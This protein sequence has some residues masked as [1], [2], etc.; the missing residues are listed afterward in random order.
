MWPRTVEVML[1]T[2]LLVSPFIF[3]YEPHQTV[4]WVLTFGSCMLVYVFS[5]SSFWHRLARAHV[6]TF[7]VGL[8][9]CGT[10]YVLGGHPAPP[11]FQ[12]LMITGLLI[13]MMAVIPS[14]CDVPPYKWQDFYESRQK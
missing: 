5:F 12:N 13:A 2:W 10:A 7:V 9:L 8:A 6:G 14:H 11:V 1:A 3:G 4:L